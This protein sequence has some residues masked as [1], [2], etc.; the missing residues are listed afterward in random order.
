MSL[1]SIINELVV[2]NVD[3]SMRFYEENFG[4]NIE[5]TDGIPIT[6][7]QMK[8]D[9]QV[10]MLEEY[11]EVKGSINNFPSKTNSSNLIKFEY[12]NVEEISILYKKL[13]EINVEF[14]MEYTKTDYGKVEFG[15]YDLDK[16]MIIISAIV[17]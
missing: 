12:D 7:V 1:I 13:K 17:G 14:F 6:W 16:N 10:I 3:D 11:N 15:V 8:K 9:N 4:F 2:S 5:I